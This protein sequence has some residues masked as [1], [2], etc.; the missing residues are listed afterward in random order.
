MN[1][2]FL[3]VL[4]ALSL[5][6]CTAGF[7]SEPTVAE[8]AVAPGTPSAA[9][10]TLAEA[11]LPDYTALYTADYHGGTRT[12]RDDRPILADSTDADGRKTGEG[13]IELTPPG[14]TELSWDDAL[15]R[16][17]LLYS[18]AGYP[19]EE[20]E[21]WTV[22][23]TAAELSEKIGLRPF[24]SVY[25]ESGDACEIRFDSTTGMLQYLQVWPS[26][27]HVF[28][29]LACGGAVE[30][31][32]LA[33][34]DTLAAG[35]EP[36]DAAWAAFWQTPVGTVWREAAKFSGNVAILNTLSENDIAPYEAAWLAYRDE[37]SAWRETEGP[38][39]ARDFLAAGNL[40][41]TSTGAGT[42][43]GELPET[44]RAFAEDC[45]TLSNADP[46]VTY[47]WGASDQQRRCI[48]IDAITHQV[49]SVSNENPDPVL[50]QETREYLAYR[51][52]NPDKVYWGETD[53]GWVEVIDLEDGRT[54]PDLS[55]ALHD[56]AQAMLDYQRALAD[57]ELAVVRLDDGDYLAIALDDPRVD[58]KLRAGETAEHAG[59]RVLEE[60][61]DAVADLIIALSEKQAVLD[62]ALSAKPQASDP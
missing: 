55:D 40:T 3:S 54:V 13:M 22:T 9:E 37:Q 39:L 7:G 45:L 1:R 5:T 33:L 56:A 42:Q 28:D 46:V 23:Y 60:S 58:A 49:R 32:G 19:L 26:R 35:G 15:Q 24:Y 17:I 48:E 25:I 36:D 2:R 29:A 30:D 50:K 20:V 44:W 31:E 27:S 18:E 6:A 62:A 10:R 51:A 16:G 52:D 8:D 4:L 12:R 47:T 53:G 57:G 11:P 14:A 61:H 38:E 43:G 21:S 59:Y 41:A 34:L